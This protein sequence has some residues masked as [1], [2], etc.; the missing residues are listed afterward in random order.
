VEDDR[1]PGASDLPCGL[2]SGEAAADDVD[3]V[4]D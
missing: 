4:G 3:W 1:D 2:G